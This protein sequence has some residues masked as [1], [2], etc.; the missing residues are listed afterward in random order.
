VWTYQRIN[1]TSVRAIAPDGG[2]TIYHFYD[3]QVASQYWS[4]HLVYWIEE[5][6]GTV[7]KRQ[8]TRNRVFSLAAAINIDPNNPYVERESV[9]TEK[10]SGQPRTVITDRLVD[11]NSNPLLVREYNW[12]NTLD[13]PALE[14]PGPLERI[15]ER[16]Y[17]ASVPDSTNTS[18]G[19]N[20]Y[21]NPSAPQRLNAVARETVRD[22]SSTVRAITEF[23]YDAPLSKGN[24]TY[25][26]QWDDAKPG[27]TPSTPL[28]PN[29]PARHRGYD[30]EIRTRVTYSGPYPSLVEYAPGTGSVRSFS[31]EWNHAAGALLTQTDVQTGIVTTYGYDEYGRQSLVDTG[32]LRQSKSVYDDKNRTVLVKQDLRAYKD[33]ALQTS[34]HTDQ[35]GRVD[36]VRTSDGAPLSDL[37]DD[38]I[39]KKSIY[40]TFAG[41]TSVVTSNAYRSTSDS[42]LEWTCTQKDQAGRVVVAAVFKGASEPA[43]CLATENRTGI[44]ITDY[45]STA[46]PPRVRVI[47]PAG[48]SVDRYADGLGRLVSVVEDPDTLAYVTTYQYDALSN[49]TLATQ[50]EGGVIQ[51]RDFSYTTLSRLSSASNPES[52]TITYTYTDSGDVLKRQDQ[53]GYATTF[54]YDDLHRVLEKTFSND[55][56]IT[57]DVTYSYHAAGLCAGQLQSV[58]SEAGSTSYNSCD[59]LGRLLNQ[60]QLIV[61][62]GSFDFSYTYWLS[63]ALKTMQYPSGRVVNFDVDDAARATKVYTQDRVYADLTSATAPYTAD[64]HVAKLKLGNNLWETSEYQTPGTPTILKLGTSEGSADKLELQYNYA[65]TSDNGNLLSHAIRRGT[66]SWA[67]T[68]E[69]DSLNRLVCASEVVSSTPAASCAPQNSWRQTYGYDRFGNRW[70]SSS[71]GFTVDDV[72]EF[73]AETTIDKS[74]NRLNIAGYDTAGNQTLFTPWSLTYD[75]EN[76]LQSATSASNGSSWFTYDGDGRRIRKVTA[77]PGFQTTF[78]VYDASGRLAAEYSTQPTPSITTYLFSDILGTPRAITAQDGSVVDCSDYSPFGRVLETSTRS[79]PCHASPSHALQ[80]FTGMERDRETGLDWFSSRYYSGAQGRFSSADRLV[81]KKNWV[82]EPQRWNRYAYAL[83]NPLK[84]LDRDGHDAIAAFFLGEDYRDVSTFEVIFSKETLS[85]I[86][87]GWDTFLHEHE[88]ITFGLSPF[89]T[90]KVDLAFSVLGGPAGK[91]GKSTTTKIAFDV[92]PEATQK[93]LRVIGH[94][95]EYVTLAE[96]TGAK[97]L[98][99]PERI[100]DAMSETQKWLANK[101]FLDRAIAQKATFLLSTLP[102]QIR[103]G[104]IF[105]KEV[106]YLLK[107]GY[108]WSVDRT[109]LIWGP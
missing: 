101:K 19:A 48:K 86:S 84:F 36:L 91:L 23:E 61:G 77:T 1:Q 24:V 96:K 83:N 52:G 12:S 106:K 93:T 72:H 10:V 50:T 51:Q 20:R 26:R 59:A 16:T 102:D 9:T 4:R 21:W 74:T 73:V 15:T 8:W 54:K 22:G 66:S 62:G 27:C 46:G 89:P 13:G 55:G 100:W 95:P 42:T 18:N 3:P 28:S 82:P 29:C 47:D 35:L 99:V 56:D 76:R 6:G 2:Q 98:H 65:A 81:A 43:D 97:F 17:H 108:R 30:T 78:Y 38:G 45:Q 67:Q 70:V 92:V 64:G 107:S 80:Q 57:P 60:T 39:K 14:S 109:M 90:S 68:Y 58:V 87:K 41:G 34:T 25:Q 32:G 94:Y 5:P 37:G 11:K 75:A 71:T 7:R 103:R 63:G 85:D 88:R 33:G 79:L 104:S 44:T 40:R 53:R 105:E 69:Y 49:L 31:Y